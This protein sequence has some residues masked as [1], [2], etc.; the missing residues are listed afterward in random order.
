MR[1][2]KR[3][4]EPLLLS[5]VPPA[6][7]LPAAVGIGWREAVGGAWQELAAYT[8][9]RIS[10]CALQPEPDCSLERLRF[11]VRYELESGRAVHEAY[12]VTG[13]RV[14]VRAWTSPAAEQLQVRF[15]ALVSDGSARADI[16]ITRPGE[17]RLC[18]GGSSLTLCV[19]VCSYRRLRACARG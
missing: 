9:G 6:G 13:E 17:A 12:E 1:L 4:V 11:T 14:R 7:D 2:H 8:E 18:L 16:D 5:G 3:G 19:E 10:H 15:P